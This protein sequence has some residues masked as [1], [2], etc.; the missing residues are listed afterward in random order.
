V[1][2]DVAGRGVGGNG[3]GDWTTVAVSSLLV[4]VVCIVAL[5]LHAANHTTR[6]K[7]HRKTTGRNQR[8]IDATRLRISTLSQGKFSGEAPALFDR[9][10]NLLL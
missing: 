6:H 8:L 7:T 3:V 2:V 1:G 10:V 9:W 4:E 5:G